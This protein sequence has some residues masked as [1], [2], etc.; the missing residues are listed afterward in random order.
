M[1]E[2]ISKINMVMNKERWDGILI[3]RNFQEVCAGYPNEEDF[4]NFKE[5]IPNLIENMIF[6]DLGCGPGRIA[7]IVAP[8]VACYYGVDIHK[9]LIEIAKEHYKDYKN[10]F[11]INH[12][13]MDLRIFVDCRFDYVY[14]RLMF[15]HI[16]KESII[17][18]LLECKRVLKTGGILYVPDLPNDKYWVNGFVEEEIYEIL[19]GFGS[20]EINSVGNTFILK[21]IK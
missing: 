9:E 7:S 8:K 15:I 2:K 10:V 3:T 4:W 18:Y 21:A 5:D 11:F 20:V 1:T 6:L 12:N 13:G 16:P 17:R 19:T 14:E